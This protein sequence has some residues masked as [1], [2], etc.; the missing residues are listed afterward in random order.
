MQH[1]EVILH[2]KIST[3][4]K[5]LKELESADKQ[6]WRTQEYKQLEVYLDQLTRELNHA[7]EMD[8]LE[9]EQQQR[10]FGI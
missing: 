10:N 8:H 7:L 1:H 4:Y 3:I 6:A 9:R 2:K 5:R